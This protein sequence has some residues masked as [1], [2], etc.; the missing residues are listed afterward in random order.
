[1]QKG[2]SRGVFKILSIFFDRHRFCYSIF[3]L[4]RRATYLIFQHE[5]NKHFF[6]IH[7]LFKLAIGKYGT[8]K[9]C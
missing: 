7:T 9:Y 5:Q 8:G 3:Q 6:L 2:I 1:M 4:M